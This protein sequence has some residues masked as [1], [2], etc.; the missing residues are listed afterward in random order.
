MAGGIALA[1]AAASLAPESWIHSGPEYGMAEAFEDH[2]EKACADRLAP[3]LLII[4]D[5]R[6]VAGV[7]VAGVRAAGA[8]QYRC[9]S[10][11]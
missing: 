4:G 5:S 2:I 1:I 3:G 8:T 6:A 10:K 7:S 11:G 9:R